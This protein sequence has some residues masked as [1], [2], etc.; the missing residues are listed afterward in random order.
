MLAQAEDSPS[1]TNYNN[2]LSD[3]KVIPELS[4]TFLS[5]VEICTAPTTTP[6][7]NRHSTDLAKGMTHLSISLLNWVNYH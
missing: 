6:H 2:N 7:S 4:D 5:D 3:F 1:K